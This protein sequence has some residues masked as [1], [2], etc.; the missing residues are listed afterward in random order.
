[1]NV[2]LDNDGD[3]GDLSGDYNPSF[4]ARQ[5]Y[6]AEC[7]HCKCDLYEPISAGN[8]YCKNCAKNGHYQSLKVS[9][10]VRYY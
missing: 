3:R 10:V 6:Y 2:D 1:M 5:S 9:H 8:S 4:K 7:V